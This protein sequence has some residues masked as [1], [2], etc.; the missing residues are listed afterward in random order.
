MYETLERLSFKMAFED[1]VH[2]NAASFK[3][4]KK[5]WKRFGA[6]PKRLKVRH[7]RRM[8]WRPRPILFYVLCLRLTCL[9][10]EVHLS[11]VQ[12]STQTSPVFTKILL[13][14]T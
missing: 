6:T 1:L 5:L 10:F 2:F 13:L 11:H 8:L 9:F 4:R 12:Y 3:D 14:Q 7:N